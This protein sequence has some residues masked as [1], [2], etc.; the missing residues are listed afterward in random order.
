MQS[1]SSCVNIEQEENKVY[2][3]VG[4]LYIENKIPSDNISGYPE[5]FCE[6]KGQN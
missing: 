2:M 3:V 6:S 4:K 5:I 1:L